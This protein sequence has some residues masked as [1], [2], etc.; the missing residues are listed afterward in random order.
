MV[1]PSKTRRTVCHAVVAEVVPSRDGGRLISYKPSA[2][3]PWA[4][5]YIAGLVRRLQSEVR[6]ARADEG[7]AVAVR[8]FAAQPYAD[9]DPP[10]PTVDSE[11]EGWD[12]PRWGNGVDAE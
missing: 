5:P 12:L 6:F 7:A 1:A 2:L 9:L 3:L 11:W 4:D 8:R 10:S